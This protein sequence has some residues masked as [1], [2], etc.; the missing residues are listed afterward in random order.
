MIDSIAEFI[1]QIRLAADFLLQLPKRLMSVINETHY[2]YHDWKDR[3]EAQ[4]K[5][6]GLREV[7]KKMVSLYFSKGS[8]LAYV[9]SSRFGADEDDLKF[10]KELFS[11]VAD[12][13]DELKEM[14]EEIG[15]FKIAFLLEAAPLISKASVAYRVF[16]TLPDPDLRDR[17]ILE[18]VCRGMDDLIV[19]GQKL[20]KESEEGRKLID[21]TY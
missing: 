8:I 16:S 12:G 18:E 9:Q 15:L 17:S 4:K 11:E 21:Y 14:I 10:L 6:A 20:I 7:G 1:K 19:A 5:N 2:D 3:V 13:L